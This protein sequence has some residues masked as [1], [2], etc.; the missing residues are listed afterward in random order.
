[1]AMDQHTGM[2]KAQ[3]V[4]LQSKPSLLSTPS[5]HADCD[6]PDHFIVLKDMTNSHISN[7]NIRNW[8]VHCFDITGANGLTITGLTLDNTAGDA[9]NSASGGKAAAHNSDG[10][11]ISGS[12]NVVLA[13]T[14]VKNQDD[15]VAV[16]SGTNITVTG[17]TCIGGQ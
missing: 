11:D 5:N 8:P 3:T 7:L 17:M 1:M 13:N 14:V 10:F 4:E 9:S 6:R 12:T 16:T 15:C 2:D